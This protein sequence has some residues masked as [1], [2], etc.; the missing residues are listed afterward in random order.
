MLAQSI[1]SVYNLNIKLRSS[2]MDTANQKS[3]L[4]KETA[5]R[6]SALSE[7]YTHSSDAAIAAHIL[8]MPEY[9]AAKCVFIFA[10]LPSEMSTA[11]IIAD[12]LRSGKKLAVPLVV[13][14]GIMELKQIRSEAELSRG[15]FG[16]PEPSKTAGSVGIGEIDFAVIPCVTC[17]HSGKRLGRGG[18]YYDRFLDRYRGFSVLVCREALVCEDIP[19]EAHD[20]SL[21]VVVTENGVFR[22]C[23]LIM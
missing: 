20:V 8:A 21:P 22:N 1:G 14:N 10:S 12:A 11:P 18:G 23:L 4:R 6:V 17:S 3:A 16:I 7:E 9:R 5:G 13:G 19:L 2:A 15:A